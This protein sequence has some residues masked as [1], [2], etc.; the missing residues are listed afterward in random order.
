MTKSRILS[1]GAS[2]SLLLACGDNAS[3]RS[4][5]VNNNNPGSESE[6]ADNLAF[7]KPTALQLELA[8]QQPLQASAPSDSQKKLAAAVD[9]HYQR[10]STQRYYMHLDKPLYKPG[11]TIWFRIWE[12]GSAALTPSK[13]S[14]GTT[15]RLISPKGATVLEKRIRMGAENS[16]AANDFELPDSVQGGEYT[17]RITSDIGAT[18][19]RK[20]IVSQYQAPRIKKKA[21]FLRKAYGPGDKVSAAISLHRATGEAL[22]NKKMTAIVQVDSAEV[23]RFSVESNQEGNAIVKFTLPKSIRVG[24]G[25]LTLL[26]EDGGVTESLQKRIPITLKNISLAMFPE[27]GDLVEGLPGRVYFAATNS[28]SKAADIEGHIEDSQGRF[29]TGFRSFHNGLGRYEITPEAGETYFAVIDKPLEIKGRYVVPSAKAAGCTMQSLDAYESSNDVRVGVWCS[30]SRT[31]ISSAILREKSLGDY[32]FDI[33]AGKANVLS[34]PVPVGSQGAVRVTLFDDEIT[35]IAERLVYRGLGKNLDISVSSDRS[36]YS[37]RDKVE[38]MVRARDLAGKP[39]QAEFSL[40]VV[41]DTVLSFADDKTANLLT[42][43]YLESEMPGQTIEEPNFYFS[44]KPK[45]AAG[46][47]LV[48]GT[49]GWRRFAWQEVLSPAATTTMTPDFS[50]VEEAEMEDRAPPPQPAPVVRKVDKKKPAEKAPEVLAAE[51]IREA[52]LAKAEAK[53]NIGQNRRRARRPRKVALA[54]AQMNIAGRVAKPMPIADQKRMDGF[55]ANVAADEMMDED[56]DGEFDRNRIASWATYR[57]F[58]SPNYSE[59]YDGP[60]SDFRETIHW[61]PNVK[62]DAKG[63]AKVSFYLNDAITSFRVKAEG[64]SAGGLPGR[65]EHLVTSKLPVS[66]A[67]KMPL[68]VSKGDKILLPV[69]LV[70]ETSR[71]YTVAI[72][73]TFGP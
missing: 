21:E 11:E 35:P 23:A 30:E 16:I 45:S 50:A 59:N 27:G 43:L 42:R 31:L 36:S 39:V 20:V 63:E 48:L 41:D 28:M 65:V 58:P 9:S 5:S 54:E 62:T 12:L 18:A 3:K 49:Q 52:P 47:D 69:S 37:P 32:S 13:T 68:E 73:S 4:S 22:A 10:S 72:N 14:H 55:A 57:E 38:L 40:A 2:L 17:L 56:W 33:K 15:V 67:V 29:V 61:T 24:D 66:L 71:P 1:L 44:D 70:N 64:V 7:L 51:P 46:L 8:K 26:V 25:L 19:E 60:R 34:F 53:K 6:S